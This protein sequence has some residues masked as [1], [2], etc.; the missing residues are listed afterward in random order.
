M[1]WIALLSGLRTFLLVIFAFAILS[2]RFEWF[3]NNALLTEDVLNNTKSLAV[4]IYGILYIIELKL[5]LKQKDNE[6]AKLK[7]RLLQYEK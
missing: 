7:T 6:L 1:N 2:L 3:G 4:I 5:I